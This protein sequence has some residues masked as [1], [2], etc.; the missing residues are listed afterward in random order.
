[1][2]EILQAHVAL[3]NARKEAE[4]T[5]GGDERAVAQIQDAPDSEEEVKIISERTEEKGKG[6][7]K[8]DAADDDE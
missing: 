5:A 3:R 2:R 4:Q 6:K 1:M 8:A 7:G